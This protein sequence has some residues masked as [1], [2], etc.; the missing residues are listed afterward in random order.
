MVPWPE[1]L[2]CW[3]EGPWKRKNN[4]NCQTYCADIR[5]CAVHGASAGLCTCIWSCSK[6]VQ[7]TRERIKQLYIDDTCFCTLCTMCAVSLW[8]T[9]A[10][11][12]QFHN[13]HFGPRFQL[14]GDGTTSPSTFPRNSFPCDG[15]AIGKVALSV[16]GNLQPMM[17]F[18]LSNVGFLS[19]IFCRFQVVL[20]VAWRVAFVSTTAI[21]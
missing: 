12:A 2:A 21:R 7:T 10:A 1:E 16:S 5:D 3:S 15:R 9:T 11:T 19:C 17:C 18:A 13:S 4:G 6:A 20:P 14:F 8:R